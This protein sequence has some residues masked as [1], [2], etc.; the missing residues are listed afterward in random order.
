MTRHEMTSSYIWSHLMSFDVIY[1]TCCHLMSSDVTIAGSDYFE[2][3]WW[4]HISIYPYM[5]FA[6]PRGVF[7]PKKID[8]NFSHYTSPSSP[9]ITFQITTS[10]VNQC[11]TTFMHHY[12]HF[13]W[14]IGWAGVYVLFHCSQT[15]FELPKPFLQ[16][17]W[18]DLSFE[19]DF[20]WPPQ[21]NPTPTPPWKVL[22]LKI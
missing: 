12:S 3:F 4:I 11:K 6:S 22:K 18:D 14:L 20:T 5:T 17:C 8:K 21:S 19:F 1:I 13:Y 7:T 2:T 16:L 9:D 15:S 10:F